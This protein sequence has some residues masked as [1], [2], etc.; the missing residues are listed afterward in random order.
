M[1]ESR[2]NSCDLDSNGGSEIP[3]GFNDDTYV[4]NDGY[5]FLLL[6][7]FR[8]KRSYGAKPIASKDPNF[9]LEADMNGNAWEWTDD[10]SITIP[11]P[12]LTDPV[13]SWCFKYN[14]RRNY[15]IIL[16]IYVQ[17]I[18]QGAILIVIAQ[19]AFALLTVIAE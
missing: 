2:N 12:S 4:V 15:L 14:S 1:F 16:G 13:I 5:D 8:T 7:L 11:G 10:G 19:L 17:P 9:R 6:V 18:V 3:D